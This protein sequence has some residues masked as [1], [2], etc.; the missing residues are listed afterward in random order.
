MKRSSIIW[1]LTVLVSVVLPVYSANTV[2]YDFEDDAQGWVT[3]WGPKGNPTNISKY[4]RH[5]SKSLT[6]EH[7]FTQ[8]DGAVGL[9]VILPEPTDFS[10]TAGFSG[11][12]VW[13]YFPAGDEW[14]AQMYMHT[15]EN[16]T[17]NEGT[18]Y[19]KMEPGW[20]QIVIRPN[21]IKE[22][23]K[24]RDIGIQVKNYKVNG[25]AEFFIDQ[26]EMVVTGV[27]SSPKKTSNNWRPI[28]MGPVH[29]KK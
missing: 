14:E 17:W 26:V 10:K 25:K 29:A 18:L 6:I 24:V 27:N 4:S 15:G 3:E 7:N 28:S 21:Q 11:F 22:A 1:S 20:H 19:R 9:R 5:G 16:W 2:L 12:S 8:K 13:V 23:G